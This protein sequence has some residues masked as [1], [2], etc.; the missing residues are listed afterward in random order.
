MIQGYDRHI[1]NLIAELDATGHVTH[2]SYAK[3]SVTLHHNAGV[4][5]SH[6]DILHL[7]KTRP[8]SAH[9]DVDVK[10]ALAQYVRVHEYA[11]AVGNTEGNMRTISIEMADLTG[12]HDTPA[13]EIA[14]ATWRSAARLAGFL[15]A[16]YLQGHP[17]PTNSSLFVHHHWTATSCAGPWVDHH[18]GEI[19]HVAQASYDHFK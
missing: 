16:R 2:K 4:K 19:L 8:A 14:D 12:P 15:H 10:G 11:W 3:T 18:R 1:E 7:W 17:R 5:L 9:F 6:E 13:W